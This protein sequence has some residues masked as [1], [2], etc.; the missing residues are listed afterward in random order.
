MWA[1]GSRADDAVMT[2]VST[3]V[4]PSTQTGVRVATPH[5]VPRIAEVL[6]AAYDEYAP[7]LDGRYPG[8]LGD[9]LGVEPRLATGTVL[10]A[11][12]GD[13]VTG[14][15]TLHLDGARAVVWALAVDPDARGQGT[16][17][18]LMCAAIARAM[19][20]GADELG[21]HTG[22]FMTAAV[23][24]FESL[25]FQRDPVLDAAVVD[26]VAYRLRLSGGRPATARRLHRVNPQAP[27]PVRR[28]GDELLTPVWL[29][30][31]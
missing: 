19:R 28:H 29:A 15:V 6:R 25:G 24:L 14:T 21:L 27:W 23:A 26:M 13:T 11:E 12:A 1:G 31:R 4:R 20:A 8:Y 5:D 10:V 18:A 17:R 7:V 9:L 22:E 2:S 30:G 3:M 16:A